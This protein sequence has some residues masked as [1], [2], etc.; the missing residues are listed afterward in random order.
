MLR[1]RT[2]LGVGAV[3]L[4]IIGGVGWIALPLE[5]TIIVVAG[6]VTTTLLR[7]KRTDTEAFRV[8]YMAG[9]ADAIRARRHENTVHTATIDGMPVAAGGG[10]RPLNGDTVD[11]VRRITRDAYRGGRRR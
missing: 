3:G 9:R 1:A 2:L 5:P 10:E 11:I 8:G 4:W 6:A 7:A